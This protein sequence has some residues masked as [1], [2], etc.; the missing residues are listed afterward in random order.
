MEKS[1]NFK[2]KTESTIRFLNHFLK[3]IE[4][5]FKDIPFLMHPKLGKLISQLLQCKN[6]PA[7]Q[8]ML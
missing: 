5:E 6:I 1:I 8:T 3:I 2:A 4:I 7:G